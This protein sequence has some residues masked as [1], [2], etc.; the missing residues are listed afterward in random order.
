MNR[1]LK[2]RIIELYGTQADFSAE[3]NEDETVI[4]RV[5]RGRRALPPEERNRWAVALR[6]TPERIFSEAEQKP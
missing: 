3:I 2:A 5:I 4:S 1:K 6:T